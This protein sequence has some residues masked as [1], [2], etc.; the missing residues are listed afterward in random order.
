MN[1]IM[2]NK[3][4]FRNAKNDYNFSSNNQLPLTSYHLP[5]CKT[6]PTCGEPVEP[7]NPIYNE[8][9][10]GEFVESFSNETRA[11]LLKIKNLNFAKKSLDF[12]PIICY[13]SFLKMG[14][15]ENSL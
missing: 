6:N 9:A 5:L 14:G 2:R 11:D 4:K 8:L 7:S 12:V 15:E 13:N 3:A 1:K 10:W